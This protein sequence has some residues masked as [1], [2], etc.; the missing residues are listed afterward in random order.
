MEV[1]TEK[2]FNKRVKK[3]SKTKNIIN[4]NTTYI[5]RKKK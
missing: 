4:F 5:G 2:K 1:V 3:L